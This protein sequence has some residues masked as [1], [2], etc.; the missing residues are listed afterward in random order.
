MIK[1]RKSKKSERRS[2]I[3]S[4][5]RMSE[6]NLESALYENLRV[7]GVWSRLVTCLQSEMILAL[8]GVPL[9][10]PTVDPSQHLLD[11][12][13][14]EYLN[15]KGYRG[16]LS[17]FCAESG[18]SPPPDITQLSLS[19]PPGDGPETQESVGMDGDE[20]AMGMRLAREA[21]ERIHRTSLSTILPLVI[22]GEMGAASASL[23]PMA[24]YLRA[25]AFSLAPPKPQTTTF[26]HHLP[27][28]VV[29]RE[30]GLAS[31][32]SSL[33]LLAS[34]VG[35][36]RKAS[37]EGSVAVPGWLGGGVGTAEELREAIAAIENAA[38]VTEKK[39]LTPSMSSS[40]APCP[41][42]LQLMA[43][44]LEFESDEDV[45]GVLARVSA[46]HARQSAAELA[47][48]ESVD[49]MEAMFDVIGE[50]EGG[51]TVFSN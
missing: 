35:A 41:L 7:R 31:A 36:A 47:G 21:A 23:D 5:F 19:S 11:S 46:H 32:T 6:Q 38:A 8:R 26:R 4:S 49:K 16:S 24:S 10:N 48:R 12:M 15:F 51:I 33:P 34:L 20:V 37:R 28:V 29:A 9:T 18:A 1:K 17:L 39:S 13:I 3:I 50:G 42:P 2:E 14:A 30:L 40:S 44:D 45:P 25:S 22:P 43:Q 27:R